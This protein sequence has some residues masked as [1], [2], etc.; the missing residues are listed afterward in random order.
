MVEDDKINKIYVLWGTILAFIAQAIYDTIILGR[1]E[2]NI[3][4]AMGV[5]VAIFILIYLSLN[6]TK[7]CVTLPSS[8]SHTNP[9]TMKLT[10]KIKK[11]GDRELEVI[12]MD[13]DSVDKIFKS[14]KANI[15]K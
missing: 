9:E 15:D 3:F 14:W 13:A 5:V 11:D 6:R 2:T 12:G 1:I 8:D 4:I 7:P 10:V